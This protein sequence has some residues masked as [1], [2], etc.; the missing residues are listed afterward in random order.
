MEQEQQPL[1]PA[2][3]IS[4]AARHKRL[5]TLSKILLTCGQLEY[6]ASALNNM[7]E[8]IGFVCSNSPQPNQVMTDIYRENR[9]QLEE[10]YKELK[11]S[12][13]MLTDYMASRDAI[14]SIDQRIAQV[15]MEILF[16]GK[17]EVNND[18]EEEG[19]V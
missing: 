18:Y 12:L 16:H 10:T 8:Q 5:D 6:F 19:H 14:C 17:D 9:D 7:T 2:K 4:L 1:D 15:C 11:T 13:K 3:V